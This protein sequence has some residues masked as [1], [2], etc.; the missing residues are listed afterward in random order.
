[1]LIGAGGHARVCL[2]ALLDEDFTVVIGA[3][4]QDGDGVSGL[5]VPMLGRDPDAEEVAEMSGINTFCVAIGENETRQHVA[6]V[7]TERGHKLTETISGWATIS[8]SAELGTGVHILAGA[9]INAAAVI[10]EGAIVNSNAIVEHDCRIGRYSHIAPGAALGGGASVGEL[11][12]VGIGA[13]V[14]PGVSIGSR[15]T[16]GGGAVVTRDVADGVTVIGV[17]ARPMT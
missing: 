14:L 4:S 12:L 2:E 5:S 6:R 17:P 8:P 3:V 7:L 9:V 1:M 15:A 11:S 10:E 13:T 16:V